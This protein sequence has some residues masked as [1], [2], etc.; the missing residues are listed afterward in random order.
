MQSANALKLNR[1]SETPTESVKR[2]PIDL[3]HLATYTLGD[4]GLENEL[5]GLFRA[6]AGVYLGR[7]ETAVTE[8]DWKDAA[9]SLKGSSRA[10]GALALADLAALAE[11]P[12]VAGDEAAR[13]KALMDMA[14]EIEAVNRYIESL[15][16]A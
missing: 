4:R 7:L 6:Q 15:S 13:R 14:V 10:V 9:H 11:M 12:G 2:R 3:V 1:N 5:L 16:G 8:K